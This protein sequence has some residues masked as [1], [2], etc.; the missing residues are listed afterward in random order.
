[1][2]SGNLSV[3]SLVSQS[4]KSLWGFCRRSKIF[5]N[6]L[7]Q[8]GSRW[9]FCSITHRPLTAA[10]SISSAALGPMPWP[11][12]MYFSL[13]PGLKPTSSPSLQQQQHRQVV[14]Y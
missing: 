10:A 9:Q 13:P 12:A 11:S 7:S 1:M 8:R 2:P 4:L 5:S 3:G 6:V 14:T